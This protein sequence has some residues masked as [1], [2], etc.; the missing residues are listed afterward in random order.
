MNLRVSPVA[1]ASQAT[2]GSHLSRGIGLRLIG[3]AAFAAMMALLKFGMSQGAGLSDSLFYRNAFALPVIL[4]WVRYLGG[5]Q[6]VRTFRVKAHLLRGVLGFA[7][8]GCTFAALAL[9]PLAQATAIGFLAPIFATL[10]AVL[11]LK[12]AVRPVQGAALLLGFA[13]I[14]AIVQPSTAAMHGWGLA[15]GLLAALGTAAVSLLLRQIGRVESAVTTVFWFTLFSTV[16][17]AIP[18]ILWRSPLNEPAVYTLMLAGVVGGLAQICITA[19][20]RYAPL[21]ILSPFDYGQILWAA[22]WAYILLA[23]PVTA[24]MLLGAVLIILSGAISY[25]HSKAVALR[26]CV[27]RKI[28]PSFGA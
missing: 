7:V 26:A 5:F 10:L 27:E 21:T 25:Y 18:Y 6:V 3:G 19:S 2:I 16:V 9:L 20:L 23:Q 17:T 1:T 11:F 14:L 24:P 13:G 4:L 22:A 12:E 8:M 15:V 28:P